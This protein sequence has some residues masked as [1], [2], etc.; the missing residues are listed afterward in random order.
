[1]GI[2]MAMLEAERTG[3]IVFWSVNDS[4]NGVVLVADTVGDDVTANILKM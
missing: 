4:V 1:M 2:V 3:M